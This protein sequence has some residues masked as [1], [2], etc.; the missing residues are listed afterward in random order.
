L[1]AWGGSKVFYAEAP[2]GSA[3]TGDLGGNVALA[4]SLRA[5]FDSTTKVITL[6]YKTTTD[7]DWIQFGSFGITDPGNGA[8]G[9]ANWS[10]TD[11]DQFCFDVYGWSEEMAIGSGKIYADNFQATG[12]TAPVSIHV[13]Q[14]NGIAPVPAGDPSYPV[15]WIAPLAATQFKLQYSLDNGTTW[16]AMTPMPTDLVTGRSYDWPVPVTKNNK[17]KCLV[18]ITGYNEDG[19]KIGTGVSEPFTIEVASI[20]APIE[21]AIVPKGTADYPVTWVTSGIAEDVSKAQV[22]YTL[23]NSGIWNRAA[24][25]VEDPLT[26]FP[27]DVPSP[28]NPKNAKL[29]VVFKDASGNIVATAISGVF[30]IE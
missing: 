13:L 15:S 28:A 20:T 18:K 7:S 3:E 22:F 30:R 26:G 8:D 24:G 29:K 10:M 11:T 23:G 21:G 16:K 17:S 4:G 12:V 9:N 6:D 25:M 19:D 5:S 14:P 1:G 27:W 2:G